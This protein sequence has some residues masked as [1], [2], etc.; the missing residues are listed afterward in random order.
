LTLR[1]F[2]AVNRT[3]EPAAIA[4]PCSSFHDLPK[5]FPASST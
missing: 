3:M 2:T 5:T 1:K 4:A